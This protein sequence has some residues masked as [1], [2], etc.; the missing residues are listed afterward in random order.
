MPTFIVESYA[1]DSDV[2]D[3]RAR[4]RRASELGPEVTYIRTTVMPSDQVVLH[5]FEAASAAGLRQAVSAAEL[6]CDRIVE[7]LELGDPGVTTGRGSS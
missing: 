6:D 7:V 3:Q 4:A 1:A 5:Q 2:A